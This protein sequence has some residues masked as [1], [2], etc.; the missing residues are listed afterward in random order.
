MLLQLA[1]RAARL[2]QVLGQEEIRYK[3]AYS[4]ALTIWMISTFNFS[5][6]FTVQALSKV[7]LTLPPELCLLKSRPYS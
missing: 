3:F 1:V 6:L 4:F 7:S 2:E 5:F